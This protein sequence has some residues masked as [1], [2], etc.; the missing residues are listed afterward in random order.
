MDIN[1]RKNIKQIYIF[2]WTIIANMLLYRKKKRGAILWQMI[3]IKKL[4]L[5]KEKVI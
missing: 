1:L 5:L 4:K 3:R 2:P